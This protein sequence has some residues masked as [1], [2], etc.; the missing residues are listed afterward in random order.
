[1]SDSILT[2]DIGN[3]RSHWGRFEADQLVEHGNLPS[4]SAR[5]DFNTLITPKGQ[6]PPDGII[7]CSVVPRVSEVLAEQAES[8]GVPIRF[9][10]H[11]KAGNLRIQYPKPAQL[12]PDRIANALGGLLYAEPP[13]I[14]IDMGTAVTLD[15]VTRTNGYEGGVIAPGFAFLSEYLTEK[16]AL[17]PPLDLDS[18]HRRTG[19]GRTTKE[20]MEIGCTKGFSGMIRELVAT[21]TEEV[22]SIDHQQAK[23]LVT[24]GSFQWVKESW[25]GELPFYP[26]LTLEGLHSRSKDLLCEAD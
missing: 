18:I 17:L 15:V 16:T 19:I 3:S 10:T 26:H 21:T 13:F 7:A 12:G 2:I 25:M 8:A 4:R 23:V 5:L 6:N 1:M 9:L 11:E 14:V 24:G 20:A 22:E